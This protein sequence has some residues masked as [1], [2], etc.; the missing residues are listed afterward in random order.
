MRVNVLQDST[1]RSSTRCKQKEGNLFFW[2]SWIWR[3]WILTWNL[4]S[5][6]S[7]LYSKYFCLSIR[8]CR[9]K[10]TLSWLHDGSTRSTLAEREQQSIKLAEIYSK[11]DNT[12]KVT[13]Y[14]DNVGNLSQDTKNIRSKSITLLKTKVTRMKLCGGK[15]SATTVLTLGLW[16]NPIYTRTF[17]LMLECIHSHHHQLIQECVS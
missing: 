13:S 2:S 8:Y 14:L 3:L 16:D 7:S 17:S 12:E 5:G 6:C 10:R 9:D 1:G 4:S 11:T 15:R